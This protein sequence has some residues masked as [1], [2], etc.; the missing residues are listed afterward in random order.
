MC[1][2]YDV[3]KAPLHA[4]PKNQDTPHGAEDSLYVIFTMDGWM[5]GSIH[6]HNM[7]VDLVG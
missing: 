6:V 5:D 7:E 3:I 1:T 4:K 2:L